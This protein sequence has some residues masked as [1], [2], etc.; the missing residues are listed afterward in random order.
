MSLPEPARRAK[1]LVADDHAL[2]SEG[3]RHIIS[4]EHDIVG[5][6]HTGEHLVRE[7]L[8]QRPDVL[9]VDVSMPDVNGIEAV[10]A[11]RK[12]G[13]AAGVVF[14]TMHQ[15]A[16]FLHRAMQA[17]A[18]GFV[19]KQAAPS[20][21]LAA[22]RAAAEGRTHPVAMPASVTSAKPAEAAVRLTVR[23]RQVL[24]LLAQGHS[25]R[26]AG[27]LLKLSPRTVEYY[28]YQLMDQLGI[29]TSAELV[30]FAMRSGVL[31]PS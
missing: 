18:A 13:C 16:A 14:V 15:E 24:K 26:E 5:L 30:Q 23:Q 29:E 20:E 25:A 11:L 9:V 21:L 1:V 6:V 12:Q 22:V 17:G 8:A 27:D 3:L 28:K 4:A 10:E 2:V 19:L 7:A 31:D